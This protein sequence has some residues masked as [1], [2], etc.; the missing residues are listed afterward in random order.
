MKPQA[1]FKRKF[2][3]RKFQGHIG[4]LYRGV[5]DLCGCAVIGEGGLAFLSDRELPNSGLVVVTFKIP[6]DVLVSVR[7]EIKNVRF[8][9]DIKMYFHGIQFF[10]LPIEERRKIRSYVSSRTQNEELV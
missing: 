5:Y 9:N 1:A 4:V 3:R 6:G 8:R 10:V 2:P 7:G